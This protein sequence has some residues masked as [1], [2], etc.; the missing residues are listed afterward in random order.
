MMHTLLLL[1][2]GCLA[3]TAFGTKTDAVKLSEEDLKLV[4]YL[5]SRMECSTT[6][7]R[8]RLLENATEG[9]RDTFKDAAT[10]TCAVV[11]SSGALLHN[12]YGQEIDAH[13]IVF[14]FN[15]APTKGYEKFV[16]NKTDVRLGWD[17]DEFAH[18]QSIARENNLWYMSRPGAAMMSH[19]YPTNLGVVGEHSALTTGFLGM[20][21][22]FFTC[23]SVDSYEMTPSTYAATSLY[24]YYDKS[25]VVQANNNEY[26]SSFKA[27]HDLWEQLSVTTKEDVSM[28]GKTHTIGFGQ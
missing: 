20:F 25:L 11:S 6:L 8:R 21:L 23:A 13:D 28:T 4:C 24:H 15:A 3:T 19:L 1:F 10:K 5:K 18:D 16:G 22:A 14:R 7:A 2:T 26:H 9:L 12:A 17:F 27:E